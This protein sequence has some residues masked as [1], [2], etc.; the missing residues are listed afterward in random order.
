MENL[1]IAELLK[2]ANKYQLDLSKR[3]YNFAQINKD[4]LDKK[5]H[6]KLIGA[7]RKLNKVCYEN[8]KLEY[9]LTAYHQTAEQ[10]KLNLYE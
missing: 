10:L 4:K 1:Q 5:S 6:A 8:V 7:S 9:K 3:L 2:Q